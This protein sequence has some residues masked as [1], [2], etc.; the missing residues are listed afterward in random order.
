L[1]YFRGIAPGGTTLIP[2]DADASEWNNRDLLW[3]HGTPCQADFQEILLYVESEWAGNTRSWVRWE[4]EVLNELH[5][6][7]LTDCGA[8]VLVTSLPEARASTRS[9]DHALGIVNDA[10]QKYCRR[11][12]GDLMHVLLSPSRAP[13]AVC[14]ARGIIYYAALRSPA[15][16]G[17]EDCLCPGN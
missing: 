9:E 15:V 13:N 17:P 10:T 1:N 6:L 2:A 11:G 5:K 12:T 4:H 3:C 14:R 16:L 8:K 7:L